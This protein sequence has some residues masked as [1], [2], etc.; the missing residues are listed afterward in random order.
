MSTDIVPQDS[1]VHTAQRRTS[2]TQ[3]SGCQSERRLHEGLQAVLGSATS[4]RHGSQ[5]AAWI[6]LVKL[7]GAK[8]PAPGVAP[9]AAANFCSALWLVLPE[10]EDAAAAA[11][12]LPT[13]TV[14]HVPAEASPG[15]IDPPSG[16]TAF[17][18]EIQAGATEMDFCSKDSED[19]FLLHLKDTEGSGHC[20]SLFK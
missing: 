20:E 4:R 15:P 9:G 1:E 5:R 6:L 11:T 10:D 13:M 18:G 3:S 14:A 12:G 7:P 2:V 16:D 19:V 17:Q 8:Q